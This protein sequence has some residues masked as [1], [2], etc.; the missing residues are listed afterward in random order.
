M[1]T[2]GVDD[3]QFNPEEFETKSELANVA[4]RIVLKCLYT[5]RIGRPDC[6]WSINRLAR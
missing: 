4:T 5:A 6:L 2:P 1:S 3:H